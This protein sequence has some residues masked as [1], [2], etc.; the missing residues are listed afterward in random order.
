MTTDNRNATR[1]RAPY[2][3]GNYFDISMWRVSLLPCNNS[4]TGRCFTKLFFS[5]TNITNKIRTV[6]L[7]I[8]NV[9]NNTYF[10]GYCSSGMFHWVR[11]FQ[12]VEPKT[13]R[14]KKKVKESVTALEWPTG[15]QEVKV[16]RF[17]DNG[18]EWW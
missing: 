15:F 10:E 17:H 3:V 8:E 14:K 9:N 16:H 1:T 4:D 18:T 6:T 11:V 7:G 13:V 12:N 2:F 5:R